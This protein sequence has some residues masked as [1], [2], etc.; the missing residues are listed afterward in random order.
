MAARKKTPTFKRFQ[1]FPK[2]GLKF[3]KELRKNNTREWFLANKPRYEQHVLE[4][5]KA[6]VE[7]GEARILC[8]VD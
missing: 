4:H 7:E 5:L 3:L 1:G 8:E 6:V 2:E